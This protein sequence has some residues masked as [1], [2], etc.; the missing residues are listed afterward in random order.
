MHLGQTAG[1]LGR[2]ECRI[3]REVRESVDEALPVLGEAIVVG[4]VRVRDEGFEKG[5]L[6][7]VAL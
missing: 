3:G 4:K 1:E 7:V 2:G 6:A 5:P